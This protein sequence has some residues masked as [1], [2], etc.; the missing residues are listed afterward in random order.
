M[1]K[2]RDNEIARDI[3][4]GKI[5]ELYCIK[6]GYCNPNDHSY[7]QK[8]KVWNE[9]TTITI[10]GERCRDYY[11]NIQSNSNI[12]A[13]LKKDTSISDYFETSFK[14]IRKNKLKKINQYQN[15]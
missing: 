6:T 11:I 1:N 13:L 4:S 15:I 10:N 7:G 5:T 14:E 8:Y 9:F 3:I 12:A 2:R